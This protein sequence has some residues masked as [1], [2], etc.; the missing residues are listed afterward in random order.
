[1]LGNGDMLFKEVGIYEPIRYQGAFI[2]NN[3]LEKVV[4]YIEAEEKIYIIEIYCKK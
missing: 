3:E 1:M 4:N 2:S